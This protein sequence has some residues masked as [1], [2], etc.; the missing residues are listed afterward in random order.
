[1]NRRKFT[2]SLLLGSSAVA[3]GRNTPTVC[4]EKKIIRPKRLQ[5][6]D[7]VGVITPASYISDEGLEKSVNNLEHLGLKVELGKHI[8]SRHGDFAGTDAQRL[9]DLHEMF[10]NQHIDAI[11]CARG[12]YGSNRILPQIDYKLIKKNPKVF[13]GYSDITAMHCAIRKFSGLVTFHGPVGNSDLTDYTMS[14]LQKVLFQGL[15][16]QV[17]KL[18]DQNQ[19]RGITDT[20]FATKIINGGIAEGELIGGNLSLL[21]GSFGTPYAPDIKGKILLIEDIG[22]KPYRIDRMLTSMRQAWPLDKVAG[23]A[24]GVFNDCENKKDSQ[25]LD[26]E[27]TLND[28]LGDLNVPIIYGLSYGHIDNMCTLPMGIN[29]KLNTNNQT[30]TLLETSVV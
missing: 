8:R 17:I 14:E 19:A 29:A 9:E 13:I 15:T 10:A 27:Q 21:A 20:A 7:R 4:K 1:M 2:S 22:E 16:N 12:G 23:I 5:Q 6:G 3:F 25:A 26:L 24:L 11:W 18:S 28:R 30:L